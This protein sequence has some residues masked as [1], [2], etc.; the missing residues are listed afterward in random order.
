MMDEAVADTAQRKRCAIY[1]RTSRGGGACPDLDSLTYQQDICS[2]YILSQRHRGWL[3]LDSRYEDAATSG[4]TMER[5]GFRRLIADIEQGRVDIVVVYK[6]DR[7]TRSLSHFMRL[8]EIL[9]QYGVTFVSATQAFDAT[10]SMGRLVLNILL[11]FAEFEREIAAER[12]AARIRT[13][14]STGRMATNRLPTGYDYVDGRFVVN[15][16]EAQIIRE[17][18]EQYLEHKSTHKVSA[19][20]CAKGHRTKAWNTVRGKV[21]GGG[22]ISA[23]VVHSFLG[24]RVYVG[25]I[26][27]KGQI[28]PGSHQPIISREVWDA[29]QVVRIGNAKP[30][31]R[32]TGGECLLAGFLYDHHGRR[33]LVDKNRFHRRNNRYYLS[34]LRFSSRA[35]QLKLLRVDGPILEEAVLEG[36]CRFLCDPEELGGVL[37]AHSGYV[38]RAPT[39][40]VRGPVAAKR[41][42]TSSRSFLRLALQTLIRRVEVSPKRIRII[43]GRDALCALLS[44]EI[45]PDAGSES[46]ASVSSVIHM[47]EINAPRTASK[48]TIDLPATPPRRGVR[49]NRKMVNLINTAREIQAA[50]DANRHL[51]FKDATARFK[52]G[53]SYRERIMRLNYLAPD[54]QVA[55]LDGAQPTDLTWK[56][57]LYGYLP[58]DWHEQRSLL[59]FPS[60]RPAQ[61]HAY[62]PRGRG[63]VSDPP[64]R[65]TTVLERLGKR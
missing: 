33:M 53:V 29:V 15:E 57:L 9:N 51:S 55:I 65:D 58:M 48:E 24:N 62:S 37:R 22:R 4:G 39:L 11:T 10:D 34:G 36:I 46:A 1:T 56:R 8:V 13:I 25:E 17:A 38:P 47:I 27:H 50:I 20:L 6:I 26:E 32:S 18:F 54:I 31:G 43:L 12:S 7:L 23:S 3:E 40:V 35:Q 63:M 44:D 21:R 42:R 16:A 60:R 41:L 59:G 2:T 45:R 61:L 5:P 28:Y 49:R 52:G 30:R 14:A 19:T 64:G